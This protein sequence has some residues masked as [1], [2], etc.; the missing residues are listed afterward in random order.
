[1]CSVCVVREDMKHIIMTCD[2][3]K[4][5]RSQLFD[6]L[7]QVLDTTFKFIQILR[8]IIVT[9]GPLAVFMDEIHVKP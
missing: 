9:G 4:K 3:Y 7:Y 5:S 2:K 6:N 8:D 1:M